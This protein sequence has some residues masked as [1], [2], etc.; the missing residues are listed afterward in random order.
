M[1][2]ELRELAFKLAPASELRKAALNAGMRP[3]HEDGRIKVLNGT[4]TPEEIARVSQADVA[5]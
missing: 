2:A 1:N 4:T 5:G 3:L